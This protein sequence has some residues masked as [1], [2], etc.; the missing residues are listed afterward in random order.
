MNSS[1]ALKIDQLGSSTPS[2]HDPR[3]LFRGFSRML[4]SG[5]IVGLV[6]SNGSGKTTLL[7]LLAGEAE[8][9]EGSCEWNHPY[10][11]PG[12]GGVY[13][14]QGIAPCLVPW[15]KVESHRE[16][17]ANGSPHEDRLK[18]LEES[19]FYR[20]K[21]AT[22]SGGERQIALMRLLAVVPWQVCLLDE[23][24]SALDGERS[25]EALLS[26]RDGAKRT[27]GTVVVVLHRLEQVAY[28]ADEIWAISESR[29]KV[30]SWCNKWAGNEHALA[31]REIGEFYA[32]IHSETF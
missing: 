19:H 24:F 9:S 21:V 29:R 10:F 18:D 25:R 16:L 7:S 2:R 13:I 11:S 22:L 30:S 3:W 8:P 31:G 17:L 6:G 15:L 32:R 1:T 14:R 23:P 5:T 20:Q 27:G 12:H 26:L 4:A 28:L